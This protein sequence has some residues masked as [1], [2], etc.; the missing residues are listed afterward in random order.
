MTTNPLDADRPP[1]PPRGERRRDGGSGGARG[2][3]RDESVMV[4]DVQFESY[5]G[6]S[7]VKPAPWEYDIPAYLF[8]GG[9]AGGS[10]LVGA[11]GAVTGRPA[12]RRTGRY[13]AVASAALGGLALA[14][15]LGR[16][17]RALN[18]MRVMKLT[19]PMSVGSWI[20]TSFSGFAGAAMVSEVVRPR[21]AEGSALARVAAVGDPVATAGSA[22]FSMP[23]AA[24]TAVLLADTAT[25]TWRES[26]R[27]LPFV[28]VGSANAAAAGLALVTTP[29]DQNS[30]ARRLAAL[31]AAFEL[32]A[33]E[34]MRR[35]MHPLVA[36]PLQ[37]G[38]AGRMLK[39]SRALTLGGAVGAAL[40]GRN[41]VAAAVSGAALMA[42][43]VLTRFGI[44]EAGIE[45]AKDPK[46][47]VQ[48][49]KERLEQRRARG[50]VDDSITTAR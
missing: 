35:D 50:I 39:L 41:R 49:Q 23:L 48:P 10:G 46:Y 2:R 11:G 36:E 19:S 16:P 47:T 3:R 20:L 22:A 26:Y 8:L 4:P 32:A 30:P 44:F 21:L 17:E 15:D 14:R 43:S 9:L 45:S 1:E 5:Y 33:T 38:R 18:M 37:Q 13:A 42:G 28:F 12:L 27:E 7:V 34:R 31:G 24:Y 25:P 40:L 6:R 29:T